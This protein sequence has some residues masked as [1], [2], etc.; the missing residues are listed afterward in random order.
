MKIT[1]DKPK[2]SLICSRRV[3]LYLASYHTCFLDSMIFYRL[4]N[5]FSPILV[6]LFKFCS[7]SGTGAL[8][9][10]KSRLFGLSACKIFDITPCRC[11]F[12][13]IS[14]N[15]LNAAAE[16]GYEILMSLGR[17]QVC[18]IGCILQT[19]T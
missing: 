16:R 3:T 13:I 19:G 18:L 17:A 11:F 8:E 14:K 2:P 7:L 10:Q 15:K 1:A 5:P 12:R 6:F 4:T 9:D